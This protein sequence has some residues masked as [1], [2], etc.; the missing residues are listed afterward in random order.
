LNWALLVLGL[1][2]LGTRRGTELQKNIA[3]LNEKFTQTRE[4]L[5]RLEKN[6]YSQKASLLGKSVKEGVDEIEL[7]LDS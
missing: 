6:D 1:H 7:A 3:F 5:S 2:A 4:L